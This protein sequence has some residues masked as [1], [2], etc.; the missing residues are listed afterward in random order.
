VRPRP[1]RDRVAARREP[2]SVCRSWSSSPL[3]AACGRESGSPARRP[4]AGTGG[5]RLCHAYK[6]TDPWPLSETIKA[7]RD[8]WLKNDAVTDG[9]RGVCVT[10]L[11]DGLLL[12]FQ[13]KRD[14]NTYALR[15]PL[16]GTPEGES[17]R[18]GADSAEGWADEM[19]FWLAEELAG[20]LTRVWRRVPRDGLVELEPRAEAP[21]PW[22]GY[23]VTEVP[24]HDTGF[25]G[26]KP[27]TGNVLRKVVPADMVPLA[28]QQSGLDRHLPG[29][30][31]AAFG[32]DVSLPRQML[33]ERRLICWL[34]AMDSVTGIQPVGQASASWHHERP[35]TA[36]IDVLEVLTDVP[37]SVS[38]DLVLTAFLSARESGALRVVTALD[39]PAF[40]ELG[41]HPAPSGDLVRETV[42]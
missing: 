17:R 33:E 14:P 11:D 31:L 10:Q 5:Q 3:R 25:L 38:E 2:P 28:V 6:V 19:T 22:S 27:R 26:R 1:S 13:W 23:G 36:V 32:L 7:A 16:P 20:P 37:G 12:T 29:S 42:D 21:Q 8:A 15:F 24:V 34:Q 4:R 40:A 9:Y 39:D 18:L 30:W 41:F 35:A